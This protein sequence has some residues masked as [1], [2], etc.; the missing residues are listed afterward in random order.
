MFAGMLVPV[1]R[2]QNAARA[3]TVLEPEPELAPAHEVV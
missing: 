1:M 2:E 3:E